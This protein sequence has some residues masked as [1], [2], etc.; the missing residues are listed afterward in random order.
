MSLDRFIKM[1]ELDYDRALG[2]IKNGYKQ[3]HWMWY[4]FPQVKGLGTSYMADYYGIRDLKEAKEYLSNEILR[5]H[6][7]EIS[8]FLLRLNSND[9]LEIM[10]YPDNLKLHSSMTLFALTDSKC[11]I[12]QKVLDKFFDGKMDE[13]TMKLLEK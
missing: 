4:I 6:L 9:A 11:D 5:S 8:E 2:E 13:N 7:I 10:G 12:F 1:H 3:S